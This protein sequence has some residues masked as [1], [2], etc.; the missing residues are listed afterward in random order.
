MDSAIPF[1]KA[2]EARLKGFA[3]LTALV[4]QRI[5]GEAPANPTYP[6]VVISCASEPF[7][8]DDFEGMEHRLKVQGF[9][10]ENKPGTVLAIRKA[11]FAALNR[12]E[13]SLALSEGVLILLNHEGIAEA[14]P[15]PDGRTQQSVIEFKAQVV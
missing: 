2:V 5:Y 15:E 1:L 9:A 6:F 11:V 14:F 12:Q 13:A 7:D 10:R 8:A 4:G 3:D